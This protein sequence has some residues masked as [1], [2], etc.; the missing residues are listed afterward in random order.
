V[1]RLR[2]LE[3]RLSVFGPDRAMTDATKE[4]ASALNGPV[5]AIVDDLEAGTIVIF[6]EDRIRVRALPMRLV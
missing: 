1:G 6:D 3:G 4:R 2:N 5:K